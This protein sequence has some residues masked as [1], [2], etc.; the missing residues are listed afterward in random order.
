MSK[1][2]SVSRAVH[3]LQACGEGSARTVSELARSLDLPKSSVYEILA[4]LASEGL[5]EKDN[6]SRRYRLGSGLLA[7]AHAARNSMEVTRVARPLLERLAAELDETVQLTVQVGDQ[8]LYVDGCESSRQLRTFFEL[9]DRAPLYCTALGKAIL[10]FLPA[11]RAE[12]LLR[13]K[14]LRRFTPNTLTEPAALREELARTAGR[15]YSID[16]MEHED[17]VRCVGAPI[18]DR[19]GVVIASISVSGPAQ[20]L[21]PERDAEIARLVV[22]A[23]EEISR[24]LGY[25]PA[26]DKPVRKE[27]SRH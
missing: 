4:T 24:R 14:S 7:L 3:I 12:R 9:G 6:G 10:A 5:V 26:S 8:I 16:N 1:V 22:Q 20:R 21:R 25:R 27:V 23:A 11:A 2:R 13:G 19:E 17:G 15:G 18:R